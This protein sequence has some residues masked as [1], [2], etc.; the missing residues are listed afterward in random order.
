LRVSENRSL[1]FFWF[2][3]GRSFAVAATATKDW[4]GCDRFQRDFGFALAYDA[5]RRDNPRNGVLV[6][7]KGSCRRRLVHDQ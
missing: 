3:M 2:G 7:V 6:W 4:L 5:P 1:R